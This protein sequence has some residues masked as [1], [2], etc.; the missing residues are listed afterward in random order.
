MAG[1]EHGARLHYDSSTTHVDLA[2]KSDPFVAVTKADL[3]VGVIPCEHSLLGHPVADD[4][5]L[6]CSFRSG[7]TCIIVKK[8]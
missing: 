6:V 8:T 2:V 1:W 3:V 4:D 7:V 5:K